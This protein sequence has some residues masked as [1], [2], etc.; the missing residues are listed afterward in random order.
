LH[1]VIA[2]VGGDLVVEKEAYDCALFIEGAF[3]ADTG[4]LLGGELR[5]ARGVQAKNIGLESAKCTQ[6]TLCSTIETRRE[7]TQL[8]SQI[9]SHERALNLLKLHLGPLASKPERIELLNASHRVK[10]TQLLEKMHSVDR[11]L[12]ALRAKKLLLVQ[13]AQNVEGLR[14]NVAGRFFA[15]IEVVAGLHH[16]HEKEGVAGPKSLVFDAKAEMFSWQEYQVLEPRA[17]GEKVKNNEQKSKRK[18]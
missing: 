3:F 2:E 4:T 1:E 7:F 13:S 8:L 10:M 14:I 5:S 17:N 16:Y 11:S 6:I 15:G 12:I 18:K 9:E